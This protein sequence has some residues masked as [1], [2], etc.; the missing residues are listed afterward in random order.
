MKNGLATDGHGWG[1]AQKNKKRVTW[2]T[3]ENLGWGGV[4]FVRCAGATYFYSVTSMPYPNP[5]SMVYVGVGWVR[6]APSRLY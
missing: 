5:Q 3:H 4:V 6:R 1:C 2:Q